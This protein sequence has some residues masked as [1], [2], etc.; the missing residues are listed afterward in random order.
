MFSEVLS[1]FL[2]L[3]RYTV[4]RYDLAIIVASCRR[5]TGISLVKGRTIFLKWLT[6]PLERIA[7]TGTLVLRASLLM[8]TDESTRWIRLNLERPTT[9]MSML[10]CSMYFA[11]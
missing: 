5:R 4:E 11:S 10:Y 3:T 2:R 1:S 8:E 9:T 7:I 6:R